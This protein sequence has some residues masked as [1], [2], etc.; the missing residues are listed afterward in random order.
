MKTVLF[1]LA[2]SLTATKLQLK[3]ANETVERLTQHKVGGTITLGQM[4]SDQSKGKSKGQ[5]KQ[6]GM[7]AIN[8]GSKK[9]KA[10]KGVVFD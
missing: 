10:A 9:R 3:T 4:E 6:V 1:H 8:P 5:V 7:S 2:E